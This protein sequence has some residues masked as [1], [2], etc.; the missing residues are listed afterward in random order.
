MSGTLHRRA[1]SVAQ[2][3]AILAWEYRQRH[4]AKGVWFRLRRVLVDAALAYSISDAEAD[5][6]AKEGHDE[7]PVGAELQPRKRLFFVSAERARSLESKRP[8]A[9]RLGQDLLA[10]TNIA[11]VGHRASSGAIRPS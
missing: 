8:L 10:S 7:L 6:L 5:E 9:V 11:L 4:H 3:R 2:R 1:K